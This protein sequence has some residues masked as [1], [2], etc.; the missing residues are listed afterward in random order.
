MKGG[1]G[2]VVPAQAQA[3]EASRRSPLRTRCQDLP[4]ILIFSSTGVFFRILRGRLA[5][6][7]LLAILPLFVFLSPLPIVA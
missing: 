4:L 1:P 7:D 5:P 3:W 2:T 6:K